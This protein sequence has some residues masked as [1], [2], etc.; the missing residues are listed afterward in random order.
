MK[1]KTYLIGSATKCRKQK[2][3]SELELGSIKNYLIEKDLE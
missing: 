3:F 1:I 2:R